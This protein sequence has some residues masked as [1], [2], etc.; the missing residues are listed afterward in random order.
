L[1]WVSYTLK[2]NLGQF[3]ETVTFLIILQA[4]LAAYVKI[5]IVTLTTTARRTGVAE[6]LINLIHELQQLDTINQYYIFTGKDNRYMFSLSSSNFKEINLPLTHAPIMRPLFHFWQIFILPIWCWLNKVDVVHLPNTLFVSGL[7][8]TVS[9][10]HDVVE[11]KTKKYSALRTFFRKLMI[12]SSIRFSK[13]IITVSEST[14]KDL[15]ML[16]AKRPVTIH[17]GFT[18]PFISFM[19]PHVD[20]QVLQKYN[21]TEKPYVLFIGTLLKHKNVPTLIEAFKVAKDKLPSLNLVLVGSPENDIDTVNSTIANHNLQNHVSI[22][23]Y[24]THDE[25][26]II[27]RN[28]KV[29]CLI[30]SYEGFGI[31]VLEAQAAGVPVIV[32]NVSS[33]PEVGGAGVLLVDPSNLKVEVSLGIINLVNDNFLREELIK[34]GFQNIEQFSWTTAAQKTLQVYLE[35]MKS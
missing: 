21:L 1:Y 23:N 5:A 16:G 35:F 4:N 18:N 34:K 32:N 28:A 2:I 24:V 7:S 12:Q 6:Y 29:F 14:A 13:R 27:L 20:G 33:L 3:S 31:P 17:L 26:L 8:P 11:L 25:K 19:P 30:S 9:T 15:T 22:L 10:I